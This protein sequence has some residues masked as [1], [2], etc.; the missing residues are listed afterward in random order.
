MERRWQKDWPFWVQ[1]DIHVD[2]PT[3]EYIRDWATL[4]PDRIAISYY[5][6]DISYK[7]LNRLIDKT[8]WALIDGGVKKGDRVVVH[9]Q[10]SPQ[11][12]MSY[13][14]AHRA[15]AVAVPFN[16]MF[17]QAELEFE[18]NDCGAKILIGEDTLYSE[19][20]KA[21]ARTPLETVI[22]A[23]LSDYLPQKPSLPVPPE[24]LKKQSFPAKSKT[25]MR[26]QKYILNHIK[27]NFFQKFNDDPIVLTT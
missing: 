18:L 19:V 16:P 9:M 6:T 13:F 7:E 12:V 11:F 17:K 3:S 8:A 25:P 27:T 14:G 23:S 15:G 22:L 5:G 10:N 2:K 26:R 1:R 4:L 21:R 24:I 20:E